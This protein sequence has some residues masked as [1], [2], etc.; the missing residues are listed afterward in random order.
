MVDGRRHV[1][2]AVDH[3]PGQQSLP[4]IGRK[5]VAGA[6]E[7]AAGASR[8][9]R[10]ALPEKGKGSRRNEN[11]FV[12]ILLP[13]HFSWKRRKDRTGSKKW[14]LSARFLSSV[15]YLS[16]FRPFPYERKRTLLEADIFAG[17]NARQISLPR[18]GSTIGFPMKPRGAVR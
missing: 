17:V 6:G 3:A 13:F 10:E 8:G 12:F 7:F 2:D 15:L 4:I 1:L 5:I 16:L 18:V 14:R 9:L 11:E